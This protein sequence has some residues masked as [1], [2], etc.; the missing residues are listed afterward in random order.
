MQARGYRVRTEVHPD[1]NA[2][3]VRLRDVDAS[4][5]ALEVRQDLTLILADLTGAEQLGFMEKLET[6]R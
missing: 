6:Q 3:L 2:T 4:I 1:E 5:Q